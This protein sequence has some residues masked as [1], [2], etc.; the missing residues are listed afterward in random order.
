MARNFFNVFHVS[1][2]TQHWAILLSLPRALS[3]RWTGRG[4]VWNKSVP[5]QDGR[6]SSGDLTHCA[7]TPGLLVVLPK[8]GKCFH[9]GRTLQELFYLESSAAHITATILSSQGNPKLSVK[10]TSGPLHDFTVLFPP[11][12]VPPSEITL[13]TYICLLRS[14]LPSS[15]ATE[16]SHWRAATC[17]GFDNLFLILSVWV[18][19]IRALLRTKKQGKKAGTCLG[20]SLIFKCLTFSAASPNSL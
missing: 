15:P 5:I 9:A 1:E 3:G 10:A 14:P 7:M 2:G 4:T 13:L 11:L 12:C 18:T 20:K 16:V 6:V 19:N 17:V 8:S